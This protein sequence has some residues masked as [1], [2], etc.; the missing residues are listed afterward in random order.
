MVAFC[1]RGWPS[2]RT[3][4][5]GDGPGYPRPRSSGEEDRAAAA[6][7]LAAARRD[8]GGEPAR[9]VAFGARL[10]AGVRTARAFEDPAA[11]AHARGVV[12]VD[13]LEAE[14]AALV[15]ESEAAANAHDA[16]DGD[17]AAGAKPLSLEDAVLLRALRWFK[18]EFFE[19][20][21]KPACKTCGFKRPARW[22]NPLRGVSSTTRGGSRRTGARCARR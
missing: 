22:A 15:A 18:R 1:Y 14:A 17:D 2:R 20:C 21:D 13:R 4:R 7:L 11:R 16:E 6:A 12:P 19:W 3:G 8:V 9:R 10:E 5:C